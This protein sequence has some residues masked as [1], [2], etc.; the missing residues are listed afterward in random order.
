[1]C[2][3]FGFYR[4]FGGLL[5][6]VHLLYLA[7]RCVVQRRERLGRYT[8]HSPYNRQNRRIAQDQNSPQP[9]ESPERL[10]VSRRIGMSAKSAAGNCP[11]GK[12]GPATLIQKE[13]REP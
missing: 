3:V 9:N 12:A 1:M 5:A 13:E 8:R 2:P 6:S 11:P 4:K 10:R 7:L